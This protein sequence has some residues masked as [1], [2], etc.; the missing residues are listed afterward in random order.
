MRLPTTRVALLATLLSFI[1]PLFRLV[2]FAVAWLAPPR[3]L[4][5]LRRRMLLLTW[6]EATG[7]LILFDL[8]AYLV[9]VATAA[10]RAVCA[11]SDDDGGA[12]SHHCRPRD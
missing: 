10:A 2:L 12:R 5:G 4:G 11:P 6:A 7:K 3:L 8:L 1:L 9:V